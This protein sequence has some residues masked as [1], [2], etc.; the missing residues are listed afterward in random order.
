MRKET[1][2]SETHV[3]PTV[4]HM[5]AHGPGDTGPLSQVIEVLSHLCPLGCRDQVM[6]SCTSSVTQYQGKRGL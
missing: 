6:G 2:A 4:T 1:Q 3:L 5:S